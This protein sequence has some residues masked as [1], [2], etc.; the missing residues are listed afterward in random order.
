[1]LKKLRIKFIA[2]TMLAVILILAA[3]LV[4]VNTVS[5]LSVIRSADEVV[6]LLAQNDG[7][8]MVVSQ[9][10]KDDFSRPEE[11]PEGRPEG[12]PQKGDDILLPKDMSRETPF[13][14]RFF[15]VVISEQGTTYYMEQIAAVNQTTAEQMTEKVLSK[16]RE[17]GTYDNYRYRVKTMDNGDTMV[18]FMDISKQMEP[19][20]SFLVTS[21]IVMAVCIVLLFIGVVLLSK[22]LL[23]PIVESHTRQKR[24]ITDAGHELKTPLTIISANNE[25]QEL[26]TG[27]TECTRA[28]ARQVQ[29][30]T[31]MVKNLTELARMDEAEGLEK[32]NFDL[33]EA[34]ADVAGTFE[35]VFEKS[36]KKFDYKVQRGIN[37]LGAEIYLRRLVTLLL[38]NASKYAKSYARA[39]LFKKGK[40]ICLTVI[41]DGE[42]IEKGDLNKYFERFYRSDEARAS[43]TEGSGIGLST[44]QEIV[45][46]HKGKISAEG[47]D[48]G[49]FLVKVVL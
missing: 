28:I 48:K 34:F 45:R 26:E 33:S 41:N 2:T 39:E 31:N 32:K 8:F 38:E 1:M 44:A 25:I 49:E 9:Q 29:R 36:G 7:K 22:P 4:T 42:G 14:T 46:L 43:Q 21:L 27:E 12:P 10:K 40:Q 15:T 35:N 17:K 47:T 3:I 18:L 37:Y 11:W 5:Y 19:I 30:M 13:E 20:S 16:S 6:D 23:K 24:F